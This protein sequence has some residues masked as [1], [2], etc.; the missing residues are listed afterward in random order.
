M[1][2]RIW[3]KNLNRFVSPDEWYINGYG[4][5]FFHDMMDNE[6]VKAN[7]NTVL[8]QKYTG[9][10]DKNGNRLDEGDKVLHKSREIPY[11]IEYNFGR[12]MLDDLIDLSECWIDHTAFG[13][14]CDII[15]VGN[16]LEK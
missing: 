2:Y 15:L 7:N 1:I 9:M 3:N 10:V 5:V 14:T 6:L 13:N 11:A 4:E 12:W 16:I 8:I